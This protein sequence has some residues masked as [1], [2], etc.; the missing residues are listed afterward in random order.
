MTFRWDF[1]LLRSGG[2]SLVAKQSTAPYSLDRS[3]VSNQLQHQL[4]L[5]FS[6]E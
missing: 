3:L 5:L 1:S 4:T 2:P 6:G